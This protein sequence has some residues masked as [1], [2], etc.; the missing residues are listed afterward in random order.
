VTRVK[1]LETRNFTLSEHVYIILSYSILIERFRL[2]QKSGQWS[3]SLK[4]MPFIEKIDISCKNNIGITRN[5]EIK[6][7]DENCYNYNNITFICDIIKKNTPYE[8]IFY[9]LF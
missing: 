1:K 9:L 8:K 5:L 7:H 4:N 2:K 3:H 6:F